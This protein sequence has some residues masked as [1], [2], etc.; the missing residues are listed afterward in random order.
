MDAISYY[1]DMPVSPVSDDSGLGGTIQTSNNNIL[2]SKL[3]MMLLKQ[4]DV[5]PT[6]NMAPNQILTASSEISEAHNIMKLETSQSENIIKVEP[7][8]PLGINEDSCIEI[9]DDEELSVIEIVPRIMKSN[10][11]SSTP[12]ENPNADDGKNTG[13]SSNV[14]AEISS[15]V[16]EKTA[17][18]EHISEVNKSLLKK[19]LNPTSSIKR[20]EAPE[21]SVVSTNQ[22][23]TESE[24]YKKKKTSL[25]EIQNRIQDKN[26]N[27]AHLEKKRPQPIDPI[28]ALSRMKEFINKNCMETLSQHRR[29]VT[30]KRG[31]TKDVP[32]NQTVAAT[33]PQKNAPILNSA[34]KKIASNIWEQIKAPT[35]KPEESAYPSI[36]QLGPSLSRPE[37][38]SCS[39]VSSGREQQV[40]SV[41]GD[42]EN[43][44]PL[45]I[46]ENMNFIQPTLTLPQ[47]QVKSGSSV[48]RQVYSNN[49]QSNAKS[50][51]H[52]M[53]QPMP[54]PQFSNS[55]HQRGTSIRSGQQSRFEKPQQ[56]PQSQKA[57][58]AYTQS[59]PQSEQAQCQYQIYSPMAHSKA[60]PPYQ[61]TL[62][63][64][65][66]TLQDC[67]PAA[68]HSQ[69]SP[70]EYQ[71]ALGQSQTAPSQ[72]SQLSPR[73]MY[74]YFDS[75]HPPHTS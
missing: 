18:K 33:Q 54:V 14:S 34:N 13:T 25:S 1:E 68:R 66:R 43:F 71:R 45:G 73:H 52:L 37:Q 10:R 56:T 32:V 26:T 55:F 16:P 49:T 4:S 42:R 12:R 39:Q 9:S 24:K 61:S 69:L 67:Q 11:P 27:E 41:S 46:P 15:N 44:S 48:Q 3:Q 29:S 6:P 58:P 5:S 23:D 51:A 64:P 7:V 2:L 63:Q 22:E 60:P 62:W 19:A 30:L 65:Q 59:V 38:K 53:Y 21:Q 75:N 28:K 20:K 57:P 31:T 40:I 35:S 50:I 70:K 47:Y 17:T 8:Q 74:H 36:Q 72:L